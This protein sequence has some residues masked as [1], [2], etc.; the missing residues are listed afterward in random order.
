MGAYADSRSAC[1]CATRRANTYKYTT[2]LFI[3]AKFSFPCIS[4]LFDPEQTK[5]ST[6]A[7]TDPK[8]KLMEFLMT[9]WNKEKNNCLLAVPMRLNNNDFHKNTES[10]RLGG[11]PLTKEVYDYL[12][13]GNTQQNEIK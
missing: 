8:R 7:L 10:G 3:S 4:F 5:Y 1:V 11:A 9:S 13:A 12:M 6:S 2:T